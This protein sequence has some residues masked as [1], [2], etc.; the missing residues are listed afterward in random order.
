MRANRI[1]LFTLVAATLLLFSC[2]RETEEYTSEPLADYI[3]LLAGKYITYQVD[4]TV[5]TNFGRTTEI[6]V[7]QEKNLVDAQL[8]DAMGRPSFRI[9]RFLRDSAGTQPWK[10]S[11]SYFVTPLEKRIEVTENNLRFVKLALPIAQDFSWKG[12]QYL[13]D[14]PYSSNYSF[15]ND[16]DIQTW[17]YMFSA[18][19]QTEV[20]KGQTIPDVITVDG[21][22]DL[23]NYPITDP[24]G[25]AYVNRAQEKYARGIGLVY[26][27]L[28]MWEYQPNTGGQGG[29][30][31]IG[32][33]VKRS[34]IGH[35]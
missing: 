26:Q 32:F 35:N 16:Q 5:F 9:L 23:F 20:I 15:N 24:N 6:H 21:I 2:K 12:N 27:E 4:S 13:P 30:F 34:M 22:D 28:T 17:D 8:P 25:F 1:H 31:K 11:G 10:P 18:L 29:G 7:Y 19:S 3:P 14:E 33:G